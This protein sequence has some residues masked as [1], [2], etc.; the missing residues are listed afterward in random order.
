MIPLTLQTLRQLQH[1]PNH[2]PDPLPVVKMFLTSNIHVERVFVA[3]FRVGQHPHLHT[4]LHRFVSVVVLE[5]EAATKRYHAFIHCNF[6][7]GCKLFGKPTFQVVDD[8]G[9][10]IQPIVLWVVTGRHNG[11]V[12]VVQVLGYLLVAIPCDALPVSS[13]IVS[14]L[15]TRVVLCLSTHHSSL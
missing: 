3:R 10:F 8:E 9:H 7:I 1:D 5:A 11:L 15:A 2:F 14:C 6:L 4:P 13:I 12:A